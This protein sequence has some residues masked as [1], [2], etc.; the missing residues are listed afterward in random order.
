M[1][2]TVMGKAVVGGRL[3]LSLSLSLSVDHEDKQGFSF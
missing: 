3:R 1:H 2:P